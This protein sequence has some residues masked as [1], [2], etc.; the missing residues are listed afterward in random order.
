[1][2]QFEDE[3]EG[4]NTNFYKEGLSLL[5]SLSNIDSQFADVEDD[6]ILEY[7]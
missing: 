1:M 2:K 5:K 7:D 6:L 4:R 3:N